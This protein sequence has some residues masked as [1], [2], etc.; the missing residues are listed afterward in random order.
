VHGTIESVLSVEV[1]PLGELAAIAP[2]LRALCACA[3]E[4][5]VFYEPGFAIAAQSAF[6][7]DG[8]AGLVWCRSAPVRLVGFFPLRIEHRRYGLPIPLLLGWT[9]PY[10]PLG[11]PLIAREWGEAVFEAWFEHICS[12]PDL[13]K[14][15]LMPYLA[16]EGPVWDALTAVLVH[17]G[18]SSIAFGAHARALL[19]PAAERA[20]YLDHA[21]GK[22]RRKELRRQRKR[23]AESGVVIASSTGDPA[24]IV[25]ALDDFLALEAGGWKGRAGTAARAHADAH[26]FMT[27]AVIA[28]AAEGKAAIDRLFV[29]TRPIAAIVRLRSGATAWCWKIAY[30]EGFARASPGVQVLLDATE[31]LLADP[32]ITRADSCATADHPMIDHIWRE[33]LDLADRLIRIGPGRALAFDMICFFE[34]VRRTAFK[35][36][37]SLRSLLQHR[38]D[39]N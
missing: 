15:V 31:A 36:A 20:G 24:A 28:L 37:K 16:A 25:N 11:T 8:L 5:N 6:A 38:R 1:R 35:F 2:E 32:A 10:A 27:S 22:K 30:D 14:T 7:P 9:H 13:P 19:A 29:D 26:Q 12:H 4:P 21:I 34:S 39:P 18:G 33:R 17:R 3:L 23:L